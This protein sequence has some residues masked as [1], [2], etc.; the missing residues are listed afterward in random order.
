MFLKEKKPKGLN[1]NYYMESHM[2]KFHLA[3]IFSHLSIETNEIYY[4]SRTYL[5]FVPLTLMSDSFMLG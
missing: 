3:E 1:V 5:K 4:Y 2:E